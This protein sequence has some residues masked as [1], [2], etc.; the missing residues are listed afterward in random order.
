MAITMAAAHRG[1]SHTGNDGVHAPVLALEVIE[2]FRETLSS[3]AETW[4]VDGTV[5]A[6]GH[7][8]SLLEAYPNLHIVAVD[9][10]PDSLAEAAPVL[11]PFGDRVRLRRCR[12]SQ[13]GGL[14]RR[15]GLSDVAGFLF[16][17]GVCSLHLDR[18][19]RGFSFRDDGPLDM[20]MDPSRERTAADVVNSWDER[21]LADLFFHE[22]GE[23]RSRQAASAIIEARRRVPFQR[24]AALADVI[25]KA[26][27]GGGRIHPATRC[28][29][30]L[31][32][33]VNQEG[34]ELLRGMQAAEHH[35]GPGGLLAVITFHSGEDREVRRFLT[36]RARAGHWTLAADKP[37]RAGRDEVSRN[38][39][40]RS[41]VLRWATRA[42]SEEDQA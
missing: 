39:R 30:A 19:E 21:D 12:M 22:G 41:A 8:R 3:G 17:I 1:D 28:F 34:E 35:L 2:V 7:A 11:E 27:G 9:Q 18:P 25:A 20:R 33:V 38:R 14:L 10:D 16:D 36:G 26:V 23:R 24:T 40:S 6:G 4:L 29:Q 13:L 42:Q 31:R 5:G 37:L 32:R 15:E